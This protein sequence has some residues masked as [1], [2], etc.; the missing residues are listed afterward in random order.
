M[1]RFDQ[2]NSRFNFRSVA[3]VI[4]ENHVLLHQVPSDDFWTLPGGRVEFFEHSDE[5]LQRELLEEIDAQC[6]VGRHLWYAENFFELAGKNYHEISN[7]FLV[8]LVS[9]NQFPKAAS[10]TGKEVDTNLVFQWFEL[11][12]LS[13]LNIKPD[14][15]KAGLLDLPLETTYI[16]VNEVSNN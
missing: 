15:L 11:A 4:H 7:F 10:F 12:Q 13:E 3:V 8:E 16:K 9:P 6:I 5:T 14:F 2:G 1:L